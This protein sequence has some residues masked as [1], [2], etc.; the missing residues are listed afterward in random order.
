MDAMS[1]DE[2]PMPDVVKLCPRCRVTDKDVFEGR[3]VVSK[4]GT[5]HFGNG[6]W[7]DCG[8]DATGKGWWWP[9]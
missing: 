1:C 6:G 4:R 9:L 7:T 2:V 3:V 8:L 5:A